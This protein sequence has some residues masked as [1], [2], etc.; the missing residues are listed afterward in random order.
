MPS[1]ELL[2]EVAIAWKVVLNFSGWVV[3][4]FHLKHSKYCYFSLIVRS[5]Q[6]IGEVYY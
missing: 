4:K 3:K 6:V 5:L 2:V 1:K